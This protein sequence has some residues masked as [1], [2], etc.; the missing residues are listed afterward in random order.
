MLE[1]CRMM[2]MM[3]VVAL[4]RHGNSNLHVAKLGEKTKRKEVDAIRHHKHPLY[5]E[6][7]RRCYFT[8]SNLA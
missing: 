5:H 1:C 4:C 3:L 2:S 7:A 6:A 8:S